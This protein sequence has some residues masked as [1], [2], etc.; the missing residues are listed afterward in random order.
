MKSSALA[1]KASTHY[2][3]HIATHREQDQLGYN[4]DIHVKS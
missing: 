2:S 1:D 3:C 4:F